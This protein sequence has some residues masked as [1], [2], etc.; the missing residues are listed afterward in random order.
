MTEPLIVKEKGG[1]LFK[2]RLFL[3][4][5][6]SG[7]HTQVGSCLTCV[8]CSEKESTAEVQHTGQSVERLEFR[9]K[10]GVEDK[11]WCHLLV[12]GT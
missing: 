9:G 7:K 12:Y 4:E 6:A 10:V 5:G 1:R 2:G 11:L 3:G 8:R